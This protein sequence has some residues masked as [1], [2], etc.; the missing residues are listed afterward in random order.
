[1]V[2]FLYDLFIKHAKGANNILMYLR[3]I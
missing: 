3:D 2:S 1:M